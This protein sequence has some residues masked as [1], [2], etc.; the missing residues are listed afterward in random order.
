[1]DPERARLFDEHM[2]EYLRGLRRLFEHKLVPNHHL[3]L[4]LT[5]CLLLFGPVHGQWGFP[6][7]RYNGML[8]DLN[9]NNIAGVYMCFGVVAWLPID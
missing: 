6:F 3:S 9:V 5:E 4:H 8:G 7:E 1:M 2:E